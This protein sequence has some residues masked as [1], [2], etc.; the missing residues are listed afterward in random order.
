MLLWVMPAVNLAAIGG[1]AWLGVLVATAHGGNP[2]WGFVLP[3]AVNAGLAAMRN[4][5]DPVSTL[6][7]FGLLGGWLLGWRWWVL[8]LWAGAA[9]FS[10]EQ[11]LA[12]VLI[13]C[14][15]A[16]WSWRP[17][18]AAG[19]AFVVVVWITWVGVL[20]FVYDCWPFKSGEGLF[21][22]PL[23]G[24]I[25][26][27]THLAG[28]SWSGI[29]VWQIGLGL[30][31]LVLEILVAVGFIA[32]RGEAAV[33][34]TLLGGVGLTILGGSALYD[35]IFGY[36]RLFIWLPM[37]IWLLSIRRQLRWPMLLFLPSLLWP[38]AEILRSW[39]GY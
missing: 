2:W 5:T 14:G 12:V 9:V 21:G 11:N 27:W 22:R 7:A 39:H 37:G 20:W 25:S 16:V 10:R 29:S 13:V 35:D 36:A 32:A 15:A 38:C 8:V 31:Q 23:A 26:G 6:A 30:T 28:S 33:R 1:L 24:L 4:L 18:L 34:G 19:L 17:R 3:L